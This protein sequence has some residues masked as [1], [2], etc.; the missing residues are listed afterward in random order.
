M[1]I[2]VKYDLNDK[3][4]KK[5]NSFEEILN[6]D[7]VVHLNC[8][9]NQLSSLPQ[10]PNSLKYLYCENNQFVKQQKIYFQEIIYCLNQNKKFFIDNI[11][12]VFSKPNYRKRW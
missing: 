9:N 11:S 12:K 4:F 2:L 3:E 6:Y 7:D 1:T 10:L 8:W 5:F